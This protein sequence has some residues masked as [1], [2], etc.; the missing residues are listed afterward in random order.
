MFTPEARGVIMSNSVLIHALAECHLTSA[1]ILQAA[2]VEIERRQNA[3]PRPAAKPVPPI[4]VEP[5]K[6]P[7]ND[8]PAPMLVN[9]IE[10]SRLLSMSRTS[11]YK[12]I[13]DKT[14]TVV[15]IG[16]STRIRRSDLDGLIRKLSHHDK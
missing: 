6:T 12:L 4:V 13:S 14:I 2:L 11:L 9:I 7:D 5:A 1:K 16:N 10:A 15:K 8:S 3:Q